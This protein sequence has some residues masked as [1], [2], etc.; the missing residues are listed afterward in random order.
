MILDL[1]KKPLSE[2]NT[3]LQNI[4]QSNIKKNYIIL[5]PNG[6]HAICAGLKK[7]IS[8]HING[9]TGYYCAGMNQNAKI[10]IEGKKTIKA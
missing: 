9:H 2:I 10:I 7:N 6:L 3:Y 5:N 8:V 4:D 1:L